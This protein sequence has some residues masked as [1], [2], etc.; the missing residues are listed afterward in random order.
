MG[1]CWSTSSVFLRLS[2][3]FKHYHSVE[4][5]FGLLFPETAGTYTAERLCRGGNLTYAEVQ[6]MGSYFTR[7]VMT[8][9]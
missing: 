3:Q 5:K 4:W 7:Q 9:R 2:Q 8:T 1:R 6:E